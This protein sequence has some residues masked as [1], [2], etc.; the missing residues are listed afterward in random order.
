[1]QKKIR[2]TNELYNN[3]VY[4]TIRHITIQCDPFP[5]LGV[6]KSWLQVLGL[7]KTL[8]IR[9]DYIMSYKLTIH[10]QACMGIIGCL[11][12]HRNPAAAV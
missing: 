4:Y 7:G 11:T 12:L 6:R 5:T 3:N 8:P 10:G 2:V 9:L 1:M